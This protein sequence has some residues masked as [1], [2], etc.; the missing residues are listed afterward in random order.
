MYSR[1]NP[2]KPSQQLGLQ[3]KI[4]SRKCHP[5]CMSKRQKEISRTTNRSGLLLCIGLY[6]EQ[7]VWS[8]EQAYPRRTFGIDSY[9]WSQFNPI[10]YL[11]LMNRHDV[12]FSSYVFNF[13]FWPGLWISDP[14]LS[15]T[16]SY[17]L[18][19][20]TSVV[21]WHFSSLEIVE[22]NGHTHTYLKYQER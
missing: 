10:L 14:G 9:P 15:S 2:G 20:K 19:K 18:N 5:R 16:V 11:N 22:S 17:L 21:T 3:S 6:R 12:T 7:R 1:Q 4:H 13:I 8:F